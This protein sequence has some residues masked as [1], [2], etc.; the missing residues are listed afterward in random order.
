MTEQKATRRRD[1]DLRVVKTRDAIQ[2]AFERLLEQHEYTDITVSAIAREARI[3]RKTFYAHYTSVDELLQQMAEKRINDIVSELK[4]DGRDKS[5]EEWIHEFT[6]ATL[7]TLH[8]SPHLNSNLIQCV[9]LRV[10]LSM[11]RA[12]M[13]A[14]CERE[15]RE[16]GYEQTEGF[17]YC[18]TFFHSGISAAYE[19]WVLE[20][21][22]EAELENV[23]KLISHITANGICDLLV[24]R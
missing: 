1:Q 10:R 19:M 13:T 17:D 18:L 7:F 23:A 3:S 9:P 2:Q 20:G 11:L 6:R 24:A 21:R 5:I 12:P 14:A 8:D 22:N 16:L 4:T 15:L